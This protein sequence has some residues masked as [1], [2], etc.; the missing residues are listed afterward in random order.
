MPNVQLVRNN[1]Q[2][3]NQ[4]E[5]FEV[6]PGINYKSTKEAQSKGKWYFEITF[7][8][9]NH[10]LAGLKAGNYG[11]YYYKRTVSRV[12]YSEGT[13]LTPVQEAVNFKNDMQTIGVGIDLDNY[14]LIYISY[15]ESVSYK[16]TLNNDDGSPKKW[17]FYLGP[18]AKPTNDQISINFGALDFYYSVPK[19]FIPWN[20]PFPNFT[21]KAKPNCIIFSPLLLITL[22]YNKR[23]K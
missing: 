10:S 11:L 14:I 20:F 21:C 17:Y 2:I 4:G 15:N 8:N 22:F 6:K 1:Y 9:G 19:G 16:I 7:V 18:G 23:N 13:C 5:T 3:Y 12:L